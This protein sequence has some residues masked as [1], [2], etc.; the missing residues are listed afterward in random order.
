MA[1]AD[2]PGAPCLLTG[3][4]PEDQVGP[5]KL[6]GNF[7]TDATHTHMVQL[8]AHEDDALLKRLE[9]SGE[10]YASMYGVAPDALDLCGFNGIQIHG[11][12]T[13]H[14]VPVGITFTSKDATTGEFRP[15]QTLTRTCFQHQ[16]HDDISGNHD[17]GQLCHYICNPGEVGFVTPTTVIKFDQ[18]QCADDMAVNMALRQ[19]RWPNLPD[20]QDYVKL[21]TETHGE[22]C[23]IPMQEP[24]QCKVSY[25]FMTNE[26][27]YKKIGGDSA[28]I[29]NATSGKFALVKAGQL[30]QIQDKLS[31]SFKT[32]SI[33]HGGLSI[34][35]FPLTGKP[36]PEGC[37]TTFT[38]SLLK[39]PRPIAERCAAA[40]GEPAEAVKSID[41]ER[42]HQGHI[43][44]FLGEGDTTEATMAVVAPPTTTELAAELAGLVK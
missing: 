10:T 24:A 15:I 26:S 2:K 43:A 4:Q 21:H 42:I 17:A 5:A 18:S 12:T 37:T 29:V 40:M 33:I 23:A 32:Q 14:S 20:S 16:I 7:T 44:G 35:A 6:I 41:I 27:Q 11:G 39:D 22:M 25:L 34:N 38:Y 13:T 1:A 30:E 3:K 9:T 31:A 36:M 28:Q 8:V 19:S